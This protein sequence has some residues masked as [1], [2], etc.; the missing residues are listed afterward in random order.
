MKTWSYENLF[1]SIRK[2]IK[3]CILLLTPVKEPG[4][5]SKT[6]FLIQV[7]VFKGEPGLY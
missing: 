5:T 1:S 6:F 2:Q 7:G 3:K 4:R